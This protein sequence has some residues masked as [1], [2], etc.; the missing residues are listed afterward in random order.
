MGQ[1]IHPGTVDWTGENGGIYLHDAGDAGD[2][3]DA[4]DAVAAPVAPVSLVSYFRVVWSPKGR[5][6]ALVLVE[7]PHAAA[8][9][10]D[11]RN[12]CI[13]DNEPLARWLIDGFARH[14][15]Q[16]ADC[17]ALDA[18]EFKTLIETT[19]FGNGHTH[20]GE[21]VR[22][23]GI[24]VRLEWQDL[25]APFLVDMPAAK[26]ATGRHDMFSLFIDAGRAGAWVNSRPLKGVVRPREFH[27]R[28]SSTAFLAFSE[29]WVRP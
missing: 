27:G 29:T 2:A 20:H 26:S 21:R 22:A 3:G 16:F 28:P 8:S 15:G 1:I 19:T 18:L 6:D 23:D 4:E 7:A 14:F 10:P 9:R 24:D 25:G 11:A 17:P 13:T 12:L 5:G